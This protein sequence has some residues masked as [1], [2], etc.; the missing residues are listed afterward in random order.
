MALIAVNAGLPPVAC[1]YNRASWPATNSPEYRPDATM[2]DAAQTPPLFRVLY[3]VAAL[4]TLVG[5]LIPLYGV[6]YWGWDTF[7]LLMLYW[8]E[9]AIIAFWTMG[10]L[11]KLPQD[12]LGT[13]KVNGVERPATTKGLVG[14]FSLHAGGFILGHLLFL[15]LLFS[16]NWLQK[17]HPGGSL[18]ELVTTNGVWIA[19][20]LLFV[21][22]W[23]SFLVDIK[24][25][26]VQRIENWLHPGRVV[27]QANPAKGGV[28][29]IVGVLYMRI[30]IMQ[31][32]IIFGAM[33]AKSMSSLAPI[34]I[35]IGLKTLVDLA[36]GPHA[37]TGKGVTF[38]SGDLTIES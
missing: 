2:P 9:T 16:G 29:A 10:R 35:V 36:M 8:M 1:W 17:P 3:G 22:S 30:V 27:P 33:L 32:A 11:A 26:L 23:M 25:S 38:S 15:L 6:L 21:A 24:P 28:G 14:F 4:I 18:R 13:M 37:P 31:V 19:L 20:L 5:N 12:Q 7:Q 34:L